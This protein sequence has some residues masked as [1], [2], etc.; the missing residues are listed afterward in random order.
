[1]DYTATAAEIMGRRR[2]ENRP[3]VEISRELL[4]LMDFPEKKLRIIHIAG[5]NGK[6]SVAA[7]IAGALT[8][9]G[10]KCGLFTSPHLVD[11]R[12]RIV[13]DGRQIS[14]TEVMSLYKRIDA[15][16]GSPT[17]FDISFLMAV[18]HFA[19]ND[20]EFAVMETGL[21]GRLDSTSAVSISPEVCVIT[22]IGMDHTN[23][24]GD[25][26]EEIAAEKAGI[27]KP[28]SMV[29]TGPMPEEAFDVIAAHCKEVGAHDP[30]SPEIS[31]EAL[32]FEKNV[33]VAQTVLKLLGVPEDIEERFGGLS[34][35]AGRFQVISNEPLFIVDG[36]HNP[37]A[38]AELVR[39]LKAKYPGKHFSFLIGG[40]QG[41]ET[42]DVIS[43]LIPVAGTFFTVK[44]RD[45][46]AYDA[47]A[48]ADTVRKMGGFA[49][50]C[51]SLSEAMDAVRQDAVLNDGVAVA[52]GSLYLVGEVLDEIQFA[53]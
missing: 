28:G 11:F 26:V 30:V 18:L 31:G 16:G 13:I 27:I 44:V 23:V 53:P 35:L 3:G 39:V 51:K 34:P 52:C 17:M 42:G 24:L 22:S 6:G 43:E 5:T 12:E 37:P 41:H 29:V 45:E 14:E 2:F 38:A 4:S 9:A 49:V 25:T 47:S 48:M 8:A 19:E 36:A 50:E 40:L 46:R 32:F 1:M 33:V 15:L 21:G 7:Y 10:H 20:C